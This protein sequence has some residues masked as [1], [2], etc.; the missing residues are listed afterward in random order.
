MTSMLDTPIVSIYDMMVERHLKMRRELK[1]AVKGALKEKSPIPEV[2]KRIIKSKPLPMKFPYTPELES[3]SPPPANAITAAH[4]TKKQTFWKVQPPAE[5]ELIKKLVEK[6]TK[7]RG[8][9]K[10]ATPKECKSGRKTSPKLLLTPHRKRNMAG[11]PGL[12]RGKPKLS[13]SNSAQMKRLPLSPRKVEPVQ[14]KGA[15]VPQNKPM[16]VKTPKIPAEKLQAP[17]RN[18]KLLDTTGTAEV[19]I[20]KRWRI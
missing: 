10:P 4:L 9:S 8:K 15:P 11:A 3:P 20:R 19:L 2:K 14:K 1:E 6:I 5:K 13:K 12:Y 7:G 17:L 18:P 16:K